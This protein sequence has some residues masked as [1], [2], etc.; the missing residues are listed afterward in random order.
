MQ[1]SEKPD[2][3]T[4][5]LFVGFSVTGE[6]TIASDLSWRNA[7]VLPTK[8]VKQG[9]CQDPKKKGTYLNALAEACHSRPISTRIRTH[10]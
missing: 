6:L 5:F 3:G 1:Q 4:G 8:H 9:N 2:L 10:L 7:L